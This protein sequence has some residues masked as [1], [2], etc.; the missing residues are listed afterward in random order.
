MGGEGAACGRVLTRV[1]AGTSHVNAT[2]ANTSVTQE[3][4][5]ISNE[6]S[7]CGIPRKNVASTG[8]SSDQQPAE[9][10]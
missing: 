4:M 2:P 5:I 9:I 1:V 3:M 10:W 8:M 6:L 7:G